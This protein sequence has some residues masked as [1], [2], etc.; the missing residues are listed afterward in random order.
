MYCELFSNVITIR[1]HSRLHLLIASTAPVISHMEPNC[2]QC[3]LAASCNE[4]PV[5]QAL[6]D[7]P[8]AVWLRSRPLIYPALEAV[9]IVAIAITFDHFGWL[10]CAC[11]ASGWVPWR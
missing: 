9:H 8:F 4:P 6:H 2:G 7:W 5:I 10:I 1:N 11:W 3:H